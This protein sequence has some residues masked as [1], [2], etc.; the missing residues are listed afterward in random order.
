MEDYWPYSVHTTESTEISD[1]VYLSPYL[2]LILRLSLTNNYASSRVRE[3][4]NYIQ[5][6]TTYLILEVI[7]IF[8]SGPSFPQ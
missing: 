8:S 3:N 2:L 5:L 7:I 6:N 4:L 1:N